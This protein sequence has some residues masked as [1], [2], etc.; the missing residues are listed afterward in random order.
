MTSS[1]STADRVSR[2]RTLQTSELR[3][4]RLTAPLVVLDLVA[5]LGLGLVAASPLADAYGGYRW[6]LAV[7]GGL[8]LGLLVALLSRVARLG[9]WPTAGLLVLVY[10]VVGPAL[11]TP[12]LASG[13]IAPSPDAIRTLL[14]GVIDAWRD[15]LTLIAPLGSSG[16]V[17]VVPWVVGLL[18]GVLAGVL[19]WRSRWPGSAALVVLAVLAVSSAFGT[20]LATDTTLRGVVLAVLLLLWVRWRAMTGSRAAWVRRAVLGALTLALVG[21]AAVGATSLADDPEREVLRD[22]VDPPFDPRDYPSP[23]SKFRAYT[24]QLNLKNTPMFQVEGVDGGTLVRVAT[25]DY[26]DGIVWNVTGG[27]GSGDASGTFVRFRD[28]VSTGD[29]TEVTV[30]IDQYTGVWVPSVGD[31]QSVTVRDNE[32]DVDAERG[33]NVLH[34]GPT[35]TVAQVGGVAPG[36]SYEFETVLPDE[37]SDEEIS[38]AARQQGVDLEAPVG[39]P[40]NLTKLVESWIGDAAAPGGDGATS[41]LLAQR[42]KD[43]GFYSDGKPSGYPSAAG[44][45]VKRVTDLVERPRQMVGNDEQ[46]ASALGIA[47]QNLNVP[48]RVVIG[49]EVPASGLV[50]GDDM[51][52]WVEVALDG[53]GWVPLQPTPPDDQILKEEQ[54]E[55]DPVPQPYLP[56]PP[57][58][59]QEPGEA[60][61]APPQGAGQDTGF[62]LWGLILTIL[63]YLLDLLKILLLLSPIWGLLLAKRLRRN[64][65]RR[66]GDPVVQLSGGW[67]EV[68]DRA[69]DLGVRLPVSNTRYQN[70][71][72]LDGRFPEAQ[73]PLLASVADRHVFAPGQPTAEEVDSYWDDVR[74]ALVRMRTSVPWWRRWVAVLSPASIPWGDLGRRARSRAAR[75]ATFARRSGPARWGAD[76]AA[77]LRRRQHQRRGKGTS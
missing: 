7:G 26:F 30:T 15:S 22:H 64:R 53:L 73:A 74:T 54:E 24:D 9:A 46:Y 67:R 14:T 39:V 35:G 6:A 48:A 10:L 65:R 75:L 70:G 12:E 27:A 44:H 69:R 63:G 33:A 34:N 18:G 61:Q 28:G 58:V 76:R 49:A 57:E 72:V 29:A 5:L 31:S 37:V 16:N 11:A 20:S 41:Q 52:A 32:G 50:N 56:Q 51:H 42:F 17:L 40:E 13:G 62:D 47:L 55:P 19:V 25:M 45:G 43:D 59:P 2:A 38:D 68:T 36:V 71:L 4:R 60:E 3:D 66:A 1:S 8:L 23:L 21:G 77:A